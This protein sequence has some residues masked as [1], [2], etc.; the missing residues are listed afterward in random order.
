LN[1]ELTSAVFGR[2]LLVPLIALGVWAA[3]AGG[4][5]LLLRGEERF[6]SNWQDLSEGLPAY[7][8]VTG[9]ALS[10]SDVD[11]A[12][13]AIYREGGVLNTHD[14][15]NSWQVGRGLQDLAAYAVAVDPIIPARVFAA[16]ADG[17]YRSRDGGASW[18][19]LK[20]PL[21]SAY[22]VV[23]DGRLPGRVL[24][25]GS[26]GVYLSLDFG[27]TWQATG[28]WGAQ[29]TVLCLATGP[30]GLLYAGGSKG[31]VRRSD[32]GGLTWRSL[33]ETPAIVAAIAADRFNPA[34]LL[35]RAERDL[36][37]SEDGGYTWTRVALPQPDLVPQAIAFSDARAGYAL[38]G[39]EQHGLWSSADGGQTWTPLGTQIL[40]NLTAVAANPLSASVLWAAST[41]TIYRSVDGGATWT[42]A[43]RYPVRPLVRGI[44]FN[45]ALARLYAATTDGV[46]FRDDPGRW[47]VAGPELANVFVLALA[48]EGATGGVRYAG[49]FGKGVQVS[50]DGGRSWRLGSRD[51]FATTII[52]A[53]AVVP[54][55]PTVLARV[56]YDRLIRS[57]DGGATWSPFD[58][59]LEN[60]TVYSLAAA[61]PPA[62][63]YAGTG[64]GLYR[65]DAGADAWR[66]SGGQLPA[67]SVLGIAVDPRDPQHLW[68]GHTDGLFT[69]GDGGRTWKGPAPDLRDRT[70]RVVL[71]DLPTLY[72]GTQQDG[73]YISKDAGKT[74]SRL[75]RLPGGMAINQLVIDRFSGDLFAATDV[76]VYRW[77]VG[78][79]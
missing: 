56:E 63:L 44:A 53:L 38:L 40:P 78:Q 49:T 11:L 18:E 29:E 4:M 36:L 58:R 28:G 8:I 12:Y 77:Q 24:A 20:M 7:G 30:N 64:E 43:Q 46:Y 50:E 31:G 23:V 14:G 27:E 2:R 34:R 3:A 73:V 17:V 52:P 42:R 6:T 13:A 67:G 74:W 41:S 48:Q 19:R 39:T 57:T 26:G 45:P 79:H 10:T 1:F 47:T 32:D 37:R 21:R 75:G 76:G 54:G 33:L 60:V 65:F 69:S 25:G 71:P 16:A 62:T 35:A 72:A 9:L 61:G 22:A 68:L 66:P 55:S 51:Q 15:G 5:F 70:V 59:G